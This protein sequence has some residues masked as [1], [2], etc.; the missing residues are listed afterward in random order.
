MDGSLDEWMDGSMDGWMNGWTHRWLDGCPR[1]MKKETKVTYK[2]IR[3]TFMGTSR[4]K[5]YP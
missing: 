2:V 1:R 4:A 5:M 3:A